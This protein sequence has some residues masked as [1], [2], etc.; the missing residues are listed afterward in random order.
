MYINLLRILLVEF[1]YYL[2]IFISH[3]IVFFISDFKNRPPFAAL[4][5]ASKF[6]KN[7]VY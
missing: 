3:S 5:G 1:E 2:I 6:S 4:Y 7:K